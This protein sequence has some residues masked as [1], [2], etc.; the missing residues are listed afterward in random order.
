[1]HRQATV[2]KKV[3][4]FLL[5]L[6]ISAQC[7]PFISYADANATPPEMYRIILSYMLDGEDHITAIESTE[8]LVEYGDTVHFTLPDT[9]TN[10]ALPSIKGLT[11]VIVSDDLDNKDKELAAN[12]ISG[13]VN[14]KMSFDIETQ[15]WAELI[16]SCEI[17]G[18]IERTDVKDNIP[19][20]SI[21][22]TFTMDGPVN[23]TVRYMFQDAEDLSYYSKDSFIDDKE[24]VVFN[25]TMVSLASLDEKLND[26]NK[27]I[28]DFPGFTLNKESEGNAFSTNV[29]ADGTTVIELKYDRNKY[30]IHFA[31]ADGQSINPI[32]VVY[33]KNIVNAL[34]ENNIVASK[35]GYG[36]AGWTRQIAKYDEA[37]NPVLDELGRPIYEEVYLTNIDKM[38]DEDI[39]LNASWEESS[40]IVNYQIWVQDAENES[41]YRPYANSKNIQVEASTGTLVETLFDKL[42]VIV[43]DN[44]N[45]A[46][47]NFTQAEEYFKQSIA[48]TNKPL[49]YAYFKYN[50]AK[51]REINNGNETIQGIGETIVNLCFDRRVYT[52]AFHLGKYENNHHDIVYGG[53]SDSDE[54]WNSGFD[55]TGTGLVLHNY[56]V[57]LVDPQDSTNIYYTEGHYGGVD[58]DVYTITARYEQNIYD[59]WPTD[60]NTVDG[61]RKFTYWCSQRGSGYNDGVNPNEYISGLCGVMGKELIMHKDG[62][63]TGAT[64]NLVA[65]FG[66]D[67]GITGLRLEDRNYHYMA[68]CDEG[69]PGAQKYDKN[70]MGDFTD[71]NQKVDPNSWW[72][73]KRSVPIK[74]TQGTE[75]LEPALIKSHRNI[76]TS[77]KINEHYIFSQ[78]IKSSNVYYFYEPEI[79]NM[80]FAYRLPSENIVRRKD[81]P[82]TMMTSNPMDELYEDNENLVSY[83]KKD[84]DPF[85]HGD[86]IGKT[87][88]ELGFRI[89]RWGPGE[90]GQE[91][92]IKWYKDSNYELPIDSFE[93]VLAKDT[94]V[95]ARWIP[96]PVT[97]TLNIPSGA[98]PKEQ[99]D[100]LEKDLKLD[101]AFLEL[102]IEVSSY[103]QSKDNVIVMSGLPKNR[104]IGVVFEEFLDV[105]PVEGV[106]KFS[107]WEL[108]DNDTGQWS[109]YIYD[110]KTDMVANLELTAV[111]KP[112]MSGKYQ[113]EYV[114]KEKPDNWNHL[115][116]TC[117][118]KEDPSVT[119]YR[120]REP[121]VVSGVEIGKE[122]LVS[123][124]PVPSYSNYV[125]QLRKQT[126]VIDKDFNNN[127]IYFYFDKS[128]AEITYTVHYV[129]IDN[130][131]SDYGES[132]LPKEKDK[133]LSEGGVKI[134]EDKVVTK[135]YGAEDS[136]II[137]ENAKA[138]SG[139]HVR[140]RNK[141]Q[142]MLTNNP[143]NNHIYFYYDKN[144][145]DPKSPSI[146]YRKYTINFFFSSNGID[147]NQNPD[148]SVIKD[149]YSQHV[150]AAPNVA[151]NPH[152][153]VED[154][155]L[156]RFTG[157]IYDEEKNP[158]NNV[159]HISD[160]ESI[161]ILNVYMKK[162]V[163]RITYKICVDNLLRP[164][165][166]QG[167]LH[168]DVGAYNIYK[169][170][171]SACTWYEDVPYNQSGT[172]PVNNPDHPAY[173]FKGWQKEGDQNINKIY[174]NDELI[175]Q[176]WFT[177]VTDSEVVLNAVMEPRNI[178]VFYTCYPKGGIWNDPDEKYKP[179][180]DETGFEVGH[181]EIRI[182]DTISKPEDPIFKEP[183]PGEKRR[184]FEGWA[185]VHPD[186]PGCVIK[187]GAIANEY[188]YSL[189]DI[190]P[191][192]THIERVYSIWNPQPYSFIIDKT[193]L[194]KNGLAIRNTKFRLTRLVTGVDGKPEPNANEIG[195]YMHDPNFAPIE[196]VTDSLGRAEFMY[197]TEGFY[198]LEEIPSK[199]YKGIDP[200]VICAPDDPE[201]PHIDGN[202]SITGP[203]IYEGK[204]DKI[205]TEID[206]ANSRHLTIHIKNERI[207]QV[208]MTLPKNITY[209][210]TQDDII[211]D[212]VNLKYVK[213]V[214]GRSGHWQCPKIDF[215]IRNKSLDNE[216]VSVKAELR[217][218][219]EY[220]QR[221]Y[222]NTEF[223]A[224]VVNK[225]NTKEPTKDAA[226]GRNMLG[227]ITGLLLEDTLTT[228]QPKIDYH[229]ELKDSSYLPKNEVGTVNIGT[230]TIDITPDAVVLP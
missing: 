91:G 193:D 59:R 175:T 68:R 10:D 87:E 72:I 122:H 53:V 216:S 7:L 66:L 74:V 225:D 38:P 49:E 161:N 152:N 135:M 205:T 86:F 211:W 22:I 80:T 160:N 170:N 14:N 67:L 96:F 79:Y 40:T 131:E 155:D 25:T 177:N 222:G 97:L 221:L 64:N 218:G 60:V 228:N 92:A 203:H 129:L 197:L 169:D 99:L 76:A 33:E 4:A 119:L 15:K 140:H 147:Y 13:M 209:T 36:F 167:W 141:K 171:T 184:H 208:E 118:S 202:I 78:E 77:R 63:P 220:D 143:D 128:L 46:N 176:P 89:E 144:L 226:V 102:K 5:T 51:T 106:K 212:P 166:E 185:S 95:Y 3:I 34:N 85:I 116:G 145:V 114:T 217:Y 121:I 194:H 126:K 41:L 83:I 94:V 81:I 20:I 132:P 69:T 199:G 73:E 198:L 17:L 29:S 172:V 35:L 71:S 201:M 120:I 164:L 2:L 113:I 90:E 109:R 54:V 19:I 100:K 133:M 6:V 98:F 157:Y 138:I 156:S 30:K 21:P 165:E 223:T 82:F 65:M 215:A 110:S 9:V 57:K 183:M 125:P 45:P 139:Y 43:P 61:M 229:M 112:D 117:V 227:Q 111:W 158:K 213:K 37:G 127:I 146:G 154:Y 173:I 18:W 11:P 195:G 230:I 149:A 150:V 52:L 56:N 55:W 134:I 189:P 123:V 31:M 136:V 190:V 24:G 200:I 192:T 191:S 142:L 105:G 32:E 168:W 214:S 159:L 182:N 104:D 70:V 58:H 12:N 107:H 180:Y 101:P 219:I 151:R 115:L 181:Y 1:M 124:M 93:N 108:Y 47:V 23:F 207:Y 16:S 163:N 162:S 196:S 130:D 153:Y 27:Y 179:V 103:D 88:A 42:N 186:T 62:F 224:T 84:F 148:L 188:K 8:Q 26:E 210:Y 50:D 39:V 174:T 44:D 28:K 178:N 48:D 187:G 206:T 137:S 75:L 204:T